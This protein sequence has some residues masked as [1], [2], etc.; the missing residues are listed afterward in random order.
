[1]YTHTRVEK[2]EKI[3]SRLVSSSRKVD[4]SFLL[5][6]FNVTQAL[7]AIRNN[8]TVT[9]AESWFVRFYFGSKKTNVTT[10]SI[11]VPMGYCG[12]FVLLFFC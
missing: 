5:V 1:M 2:K 9:F 6:G 10:F 12:L 4:E 11:A 3:E 8:A 7:H